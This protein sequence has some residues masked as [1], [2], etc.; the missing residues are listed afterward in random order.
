MDVRKAEDF[1]SAGW[2]ENWYSHM[3]ID[4]GVL[5]KSRNKSTT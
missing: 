1:F 5:P 3:E 2:R 4:V